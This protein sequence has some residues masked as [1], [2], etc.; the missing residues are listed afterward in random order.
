[1]SLHSKEQNSLED[2]DS[3]LSSGSHFAVISDNEIGHD[4]VN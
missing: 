4:V 2:D 1:M 3:A